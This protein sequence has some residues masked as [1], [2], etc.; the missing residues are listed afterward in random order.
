MAKGFW[1][2]LGEIDYEGQRLAEKLYKY[3]IFISCIIGFVISIIT[4]QFMYTGYAALFSTCFSI[5]LTFFPW[6]WYNKHPLQ[7]ATSD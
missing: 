1:N 5:V 3:I 7:W 4:K 2:V 6:P